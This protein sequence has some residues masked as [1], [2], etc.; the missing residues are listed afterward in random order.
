MHKESAVVL[1]GGGTAT[2]PALPHLKTGHF[3]WSRSEFALCT[4]STVS[5]GKRESMF[6]L[7]MF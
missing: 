1:N 2:G 6:M 7:W 4:N 3:R 5:A